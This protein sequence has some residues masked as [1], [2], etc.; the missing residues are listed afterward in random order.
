MKN[1]FMIVAAL[2]MMCVGCAKKTSQSPVAPPSASSFDLEDTTWY[3]ESKYSD[4]RNADW[5]ELTK[6]QLKDPLTAKLADAYNCAVVWRSIYSDMEK[7]WRFHPEGELCVAL[8]EQLDDFCFMDCSLI[9]DSTMH[10]MSDSLKYLAM[11]AVQDT[12]I[13]FMAHHDEYM[14]AAIERYHTTNFGELSDEQYTSLVDRKQ[15]VP[16]FDDLL[17]YR[18]KDDSVHQARLL[19]LLQSEQDIHRRCIYALEYAHSSSDGPYFSDCLPYLVD[20]MLAGQY[21]PYL[22]EVWRT[23]RVVVAT[24]MGMSRDSHI[25]NWKYNDMRRICAKT[26]LEY[27]RNHP[28]DI[29]AINNFIVL[30]YTVN[31]HRYGT[32]PMG[33]Q[34]FV[35][36]MEMF[37][38]FFEDLE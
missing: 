36:Q 25:P 34:T 1:Y 31:I 20:V 21:S 12:D 8:C 6:A 10:A 26:T 22:N 33:N 28:D 13:D 23:W 7:V 37:G 5:L 15:Y 16:D 27:I 14:M 3:D 4:C 29:V 32:F 9:K 19:D 38:D 35:E 17:A 18:L 11:R 30:A 24:Q 2:A